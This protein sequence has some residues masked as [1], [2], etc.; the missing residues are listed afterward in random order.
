MQRL[1]IANHDGE[2]LK[3]EK[4][5]RG[6]QSALDNYQLRHGQEVDVVFLSM[7]DTTVLRFKTNWG[8]WNI[9]NENL[10]GMSTFSRAR[11]RLQISG[12]WK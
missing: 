3:I 2:F 6:L 12:T 8:W 9:W 7:D 10:H 11:T 4:I 5:S 1:S